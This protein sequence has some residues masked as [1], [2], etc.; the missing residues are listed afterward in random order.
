MPSNPALTFSWST[1]LFFSLYCPRN[2]ST[3]TFCGCQ[4]GFFGLRV[5]RQPLLFHVAVG[6][7]VARA[8]PAEILASIR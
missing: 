4:L 5:D 1:W 8:L 2:W 6:S 3:F 7:A